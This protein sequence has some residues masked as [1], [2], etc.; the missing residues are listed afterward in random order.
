MMEMP[1]ITMVAHLPVLLKQGTIAHKD[2]T[3]SLNVEIQLSLL[4]K[5]V[6]MET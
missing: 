2:M 4:L 1:L 5:N 6:M 3:V